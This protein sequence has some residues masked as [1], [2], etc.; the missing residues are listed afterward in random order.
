MNINHGDVVLV[1]FPFASGA[2]S[3]VRPALVIQNDRDNPR[4][5]NTILVQITSTTHRAME[6]TQVLV[7][8]ATPE[9]LQTG[10]LIDSVINCVNLATVEKSKVLRKLGDM[11]PALMLKV[12]AA[13]KAALDLP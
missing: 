1:D 8:V 9:G 11:P 10:L 13:L 2:R 3:K 12:H 4:L 7:E 6:D 5:L